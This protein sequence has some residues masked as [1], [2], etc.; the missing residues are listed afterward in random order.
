MQ[1]IEVSGA[2]FKD[3]ERQVKEQ[4]KL[5]AGIKE[6]RCVN[7]KIF[8]CKREQGW[9]NPIYE[10]SIIQPEDVLKE[11]CSEFKSAYK[12]SPVC[13][14]TNNCTKEQL[15]SGCCI[16][17]GYLTREIHLNEPITFVCGECEGKGKLIFDNCIVLTMR[18]DGVL[19]GKICPSCNGL[20]KIELGKVIE[21]SEFEK[22]LL[23]KVV[24][25]HNHGG[26]LDYNLTKNLPFGNWVLLRVERKI[27]KK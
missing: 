18:E 24:T 2:V 27:C 12:E 8:P 20:G 17:E 14:R 16:N 23:E 13:I 15:E 7:C 22:V 9:C 3:I 21:K 10:I 19:D 5:V 11:K 25:I 4:T 6:T 26:E 1:R